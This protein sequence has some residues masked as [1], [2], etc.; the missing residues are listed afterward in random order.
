MAYTITSDRLD[1]P[2]TLGDS[3]T[4]EELL[5]M[6]ADIE[7]LIEGGHISTD[8]AKVTPTPAPAASPASVDAAASAPTTPEGA[9]A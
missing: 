3:V 5:A 4:D 8:G 9:T 2:K 7:A 1:S 6:G